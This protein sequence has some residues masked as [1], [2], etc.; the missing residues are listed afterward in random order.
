MKSKKDNDEVV[1]PNDDVIAVLP[2][3]NGQR[4]EKDLGKAGFSSGN[5]RVLH[6]QE[7]VDKIVVTGKDKDVLTMAAKFIQAHTDEMWMMRDYEDEGRDGNDII[8]VHLNDASG[9]DAAREA[10]AR[11][12]GRKIRY[13]GAYA[14]R[15]LSTTPKTPEEPPGSLHVQAASAKRIEGPDRAAGQDTPSGPRTD[16]SVDRAK[17]S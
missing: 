14:I 3:G 2:P 13:F 7:A 6:G 16:R 12:G 5:V 9:V 1:F 11:N 15:D 4:A 17:R 10:I 8:V